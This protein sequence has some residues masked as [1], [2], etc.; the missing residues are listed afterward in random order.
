MSSTDRLWALRIQCG[1]HMSHDRSLCL[2]GQR[3]PLQAT[4][5]QL[6]ADAEQH[7]VSSKVVELLVLC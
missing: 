3:P 1:A 7:E 4:G 5:A 2:T 6:V